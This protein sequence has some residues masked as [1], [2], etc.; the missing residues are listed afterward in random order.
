MVFRHSQHFLFQDYCNLIATN[1]H[2][3]W[4]ISVHITYPFSRI[5]NNTFN[6]SQAG[7]PIHWEHNQLASF[8]NLHDNIYKFSKALSQTSA[9]A[10]DLIWAPF[11][12]FGLNYLN[13]VFSLGVTTIL[14]SLFIVLLLSFIL[15]APFLNI[16]F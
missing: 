5:F 6:K 9:P 4:T 3:I 10:A 16:E 1:T 15:V 2:S 11:S 13:I 7:T 14:F 12:P 8:S